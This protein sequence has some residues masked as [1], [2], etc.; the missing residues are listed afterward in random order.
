MNDETLQ[1]Y[2]TNTLSEEEIVGVLDWLDASEEHRRHLDM[3]D[4]A[5]H[6]ALL[7]SELG[8]PSRATARRRHP[9]RAVLKWGTGIAATLFL[10]GLLSHYIVEH[11][12]DRQVQMMQ[13]TAPYGH[14]LSLSLSDGTSVQLNSG[15]RLEYPTL[16][17][18]GV[19]R[20]RVTGEAMFDVSHDASHPFIVE[21]PAC[22]A[23]VLG[24]KFNILSPA[25]GLRFSASLLEGSLK[26]TSNRSSTHES[27]ILSP[28]EEV[29]LV[30]GH[31]CLDKIRDSD[32]LRWV[33]GLLNLNGL[34]FPE[35]IGR[36]RD[37]YGVDIVLESS[38][39]SHRYR[40]KIRVSDGIDH[41]L[42]L[43]QLLSD[44]EYT[45]DDVHNRIY[46]RSK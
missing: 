4:Y 10:C 32:N 43:L 25:D 28:N 12:L 40:G 19:R 27:V 42:A 20:V 39:T 17:H 34:T 22:T 13:I 23:E 29:H 5:N 7:L 26:I 16:F 33:D 21:T 30:D 38:P 35:I 1:R 3:L 46:I 11:T 24:T 36:F 15:S 8:C 6:G 41:A 45:R 31:L 2:L 14:S 44:F 9:F 18:G 37:Y